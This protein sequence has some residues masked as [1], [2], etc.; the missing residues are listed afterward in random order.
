M[1]EVI[2]FT[3][4]AG[5]GKSTTLEYATEELNK[6]GYRVF[7]IPE[8]ATK[9][10]HPGIPDIEEIAKNDY[11]LYLQIQKIILQD[12]KQQEKLF[13]Q[14][15]DISLRFSPN[16]PVVIICDRA[17]MDPS[18]Y[19]KERKD[20][21]QHLSE[22]Q[23]SYADVCESYDLVIH[24]V[25]A[26]RG[27]EAFYT[28]QN[29]RARREATLE[30]ARESDERTLMAWVGHH[31][32][33]IVDNRS[34]DFAEKQKR[35]L[36]LILSDKE[37]E[38]KFLLRNPPEFNCPELEKA[39]RADIQQF[40]TKINGEK[41]RFRKRTRR[42]CSIYFKTKKRVLSGITREEKE[43][44]IGLEE[45]EDGLRFQIPGTK[46]I[47][48]N[49]YYFIYNYQYFELDEFME[50]INN[51]YVLEIELENENDPVYLPPFL[52][53]NREVTHDPSFRNSAIAY[54]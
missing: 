41:V 25:T 46:M 10:L 14:L 34:T 9:I 28:T 36:D 32:L 51:L 20:F 38:R 7:V 17:G 45:Y 21:E 35:V 42:G 23:L 26:A 49:R 12:Q 6:L 15:A 13:R 44:K 43:V 31:K 54:C 37:I 2:V 18:S 24:L 19:V 29:N 50:P 22:L 3:G 11:Q 8:T 52:D 4:G 48:K 5:A 1:V 33:K 47:V 53:I 39:E 16:Q 27:A 30:A 40:Y